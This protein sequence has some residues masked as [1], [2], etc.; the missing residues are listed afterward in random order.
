LRLVQNCTMFEIS[1]ADLGMSYRGAAASIGDAFYNGVVYD[2]S[3]GVDVQGGIHSCAYRAR[4][5]GAENARP[6]S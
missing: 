1:S 6:S 3:A 4:Q 2:V 5:K